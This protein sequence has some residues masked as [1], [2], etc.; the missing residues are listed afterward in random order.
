[1]DEDEIAEAERVGYFSPDRVRQIR[2]NGMNALHLIQ[3]ERRAWVE[4]WMA[5]QPDPLWQLPYL[6]ADWN[7]MSPENI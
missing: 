7:S 6:P 5:W 4:T 2:Q 1:K 3:G